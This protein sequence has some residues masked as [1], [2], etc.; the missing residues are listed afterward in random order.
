MYMRDSIV[1]KYNLEEI[2]VIIRKL[3]F[4]KSYPFKNNTAS[5]SVDLS[6]TCMLFMLSVRIERSLR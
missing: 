4:E 6:C 5:M 2:Q 1:Y 3:Q